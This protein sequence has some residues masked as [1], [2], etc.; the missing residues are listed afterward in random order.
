MFRHRQNYYQ[1]YRVDHKRNLEQMVDEVEG[2][3][4]AEKLVEDYLRS[5]TAAEINDE[6]SYYRG[7]ISSHVPKMLSHKRRAAAGD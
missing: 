4:A 7:T 6:I 5:M 1:I 3:H 2:L